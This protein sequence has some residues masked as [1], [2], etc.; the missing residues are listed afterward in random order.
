MC[1]LLKL[2]LMHTKV[3]K[4]TLVFNLLLAK[5]GDLG[6]I[7]VLAPNPEFQ[8]FVVI[9]IHDNLPIYIFTCTNMSHEGVFPFYR[10]KFNN[11][12]NFSYLLIVFITGNAILI[13]LCYVPF[14]ETE[15]L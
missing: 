8:Y 9:N 11:F 15:T 2:E 1:Q 7:Q 14:C 5:K 12:N 3:S 13:T 6:I 10:P 4:K